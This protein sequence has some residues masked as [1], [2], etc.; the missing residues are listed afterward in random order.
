VADW[1]PTAAVTVWG[2][3]GTSVRGVPSCGMVYGTY[4]S[5][6]SLVVSDVESL[7]THG[8]VPVCP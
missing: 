5:V 7:T 2:A 6:D 4:R 8:E 1:E 3:L